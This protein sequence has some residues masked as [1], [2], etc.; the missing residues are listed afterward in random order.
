MI[1]PLNPTG[2]L[3]ARLALLYGDGKAQTYN[4]GWIP[5]GIG[6]HFTNAV[7]NYTGMT[8]ESAVTTV[9]NPTRPLARA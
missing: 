8:A 2:L 7:K 3:K 1:K 9:Q 5:T 6:N 4:T